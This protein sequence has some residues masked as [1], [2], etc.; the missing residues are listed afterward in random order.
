M[1]TSVRGKFILSGATIAL[2]NNVHFKALIWYHN[3]TKYLPLSS[4][5][6]QNCTIQ[7]FRNSDN[8]DAEETKYFFDLDMRARSLGNPSF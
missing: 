3:I 8:L 1:Q 5:Y 4:A 7:T 6:V 2:S